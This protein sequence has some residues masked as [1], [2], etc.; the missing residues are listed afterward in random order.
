MCQK[1]PVNV[2]SSTTFVV[3]TRKLQ[4]LEDIKKDE[5]G[6]WNYSG[7]H[8]QAFRVSEEDGT[9]LWIEKCTTSATGS[10]VGHIRRLHCTHPS[11]S[12]FKRVICFLS[13]TSFG[14]FHFNPLIKISHFGDA[15]HNPHHL[16]LVSSPCRWTSH[17][18]W[19]VMEMQKRANL[20]TQ[21]LAASQRG[22]FD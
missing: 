20:S 6:I 15:D 12:N 21:H 11:N 9:S 5:F 1:K 16:C 10:N 2:T 13:G 3:D 8:P 4:S 14:E 22:V 17:H 18:H 7:S 19:K